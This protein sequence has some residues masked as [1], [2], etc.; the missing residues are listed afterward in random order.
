M[1]LGW[2]EI[3]VFAVL[4]YDSP[5][6][7]RR[8]TISQ[9]ASHYGTR[10]QKSVFELEITERALAS[11]GRKLLQVADLVEDELRLYVLCE[12]CRHTIVVF[13]GKPP[14]RRP[15]SVVV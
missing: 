5:D 8:N 12:N 11:L 13:S 14:Y 7:R 9:I 1:R 4:C 15:R 2:R 3:E 10:V 6:D